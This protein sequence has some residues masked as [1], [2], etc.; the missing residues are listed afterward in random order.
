[1]SN[2]SKLS[3]EYKKDAI[4]KTVLK[5]KRFR[6][7]FQIRAIKEESYA[8]QNQWKDFISGERSTFTYNSATKYPQQIRFLRLNDGT[9]EFTSSTTIPLTPEDLDSFTQIFDTL[10]KS[11]EAYDKSLPSGL[12]AYNNNSSTNLLTV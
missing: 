12:S 4:I 9:V 6:L 5:N 10:V 2:H 11:V 1:M 3:V 8:L 7:G